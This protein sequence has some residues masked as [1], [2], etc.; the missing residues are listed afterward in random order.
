METLWPKGIS[1]SLIYISNKIKTNNYYRP[2]NDKILNVFTRV[3]KFSFICFQKVNKVRYLSRNSS[4]FYTYFSK[5]LKEL[6][7]S[8]VPINII[9]TRHGEKLFETLVSREEMARLQI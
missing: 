2:E 8:K 7:K 1:N 6:F 3:N 5:A 9:G 4:L